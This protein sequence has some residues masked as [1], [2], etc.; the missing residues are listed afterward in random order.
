MEQVKAGMPVRKTMCA[1]CPFRRKSKTAFVAPVLLERI[2]GTASHI[3]HST[4]HDNAFNDE[5]GLPEHICRGARD[6][7]IQFYYSIKFIDAAT[8][9]A[10]NAK[11]IEMGMAPQPVQDPK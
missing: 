9:E 6:L 1:T 8:D 2:Y 5:T 10:W 11:R 3:C 7:Q 4:G